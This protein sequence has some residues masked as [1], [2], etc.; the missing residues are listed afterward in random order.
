LI[1]KFSELPISQYLQEQLST[2]NFHTPTPVQSSAIPV[3]LSGKDLLATAQTGTGKTLAFLIPLAERL[4]ETRAAGIHALVLVPTRELAMQVELQYDQ[5]RGKKL[6]KA[7]LVI[8]GAAERQQIAALRTA[9]L[10]IATP[11]RLEDFLQR[12]L[13][14]L[15]GTQVLVLD[16]ADRML[17]MGFLPAI[18]RITD[19]LPKQRQTLCFSATLDPAVAHIVSD[20]VRNPLRVALGSTS[21]PVASVKL[22]AFEVPTNQR[23]A[24]LTRLLGAEDGRCLVFVRT[25]RGA[26]R[27]TRQLRKQGFSAG[28]LHGD[29][30]QSQRNAALGDFQNGTVPILVATDVASRGI[31]VDNV[32]HVINYELPNMA[33]DLIHRVGRTGRI[34]ATGT[35]SVFV[36]HQDR[37]EFRT[38]ERTLGLQMERMRVDG[39]LAVEERSGPVVVEGAPVQ[40][41]PGSKMV[42]LPGEVLQRYAAV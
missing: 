4:L 30:S 1:S 23:L 27:L 11:G 5:L 3:A 41:M 39:D 28:M 31:H 34:G 20:F 22:Q 8:G 6:R 15:S 32:A 42:R 18:R 24:L 10:V 25:K 37:S 19:V 36:T 40:V 9:N 29:R 12:K 14:K 16:E 38:M 35:A 2:L 13:V 7:A 26:D 33:E 17:D 21:K